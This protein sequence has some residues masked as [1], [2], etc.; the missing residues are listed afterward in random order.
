MLSPAQH[1]VNGAGTHCDTQRDVNCRRTGLLSAT[2]L[3]ST[4]SQKRSSGGSL[5]LLGLTGARSLLGRLMAQA[6]G[7]GVLRAV[8]RAS[9]RRRPCCRYI[10][11]TRS[12]PGA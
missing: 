11:E 5:S 9:R 1:D 6:A 10:S 4:W 8:Q 12:W 7:G 2:S 3:G